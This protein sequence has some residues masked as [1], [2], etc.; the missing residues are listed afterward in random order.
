[1]RKGNSTSAEQE[2]DNKLRKIQSL[3]GDCI[4]L[5]VQLQKTPS[6]SAKPA[7]HTRRSDTSV[8]FD[9]HARA[10]VKRYAKNLASG[11]KKFVLAL[12]FLAK[13]D[14]SKEVPLNEIE[15]LWNRTS[16]KTLLGMKFNSFFPATA[17]E[18]GWVDSKKRGFY[19]LDRSWKDI[20]TDD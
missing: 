14:I 2:L 4:D 10:F 9:M 16:S 1:M 15:K 7:A 8:R 6:S 3:V 19:N 5:V 17:K 11:P 18:N 20:F 12:A 13:G